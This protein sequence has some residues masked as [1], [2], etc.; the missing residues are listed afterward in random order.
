MSLPS[1]Q[2]AKKHVFKPDRMN[3][4]EIQSELDAQSDRDADRQSASKF[5]K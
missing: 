4:F 1:V 3:S 2:K 5:P